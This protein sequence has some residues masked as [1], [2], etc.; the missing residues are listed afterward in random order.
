[1]THH[2]TFASGTGRPRRGRALGV[3]VGLSVM[4]TPMAIAPAAQA[5]TY[6]GLGGLI[7]QAL[8]TGAGGPGGGPV[9]GLGSL[10][11]AILDA[12]SN[13]LKPNPHPARARIRAHV[14]H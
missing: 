6:H 7:D 11:T 1:M 10:V 14:H 13:I 3:L 5:D 2:T 12:I 8:I 4:L 9:D